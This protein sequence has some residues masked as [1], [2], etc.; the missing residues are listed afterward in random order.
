M[1]RFGAIC[2]LGSS[3]P[4][5]A[6]RAVQQARAGCIRTVPARPRALCQPAI[7]EALMASTRLVLRDTL[8]ATFAETVISKVLNKY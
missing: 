7:A 4:T 5:G 3:C 1:R 8:E 2:P 6:C